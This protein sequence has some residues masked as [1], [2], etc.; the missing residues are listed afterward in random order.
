MLALAIAKN[1]D[2][3]GCVLEWEESLVDE[4][5]T[6][7]AY[8]PAQNILQAAR[9]SWNEVQPGLRKAVDDNIIGRYVFSEQVFRCAGFAATFHSCS[10]RSASRQACIIAQSQVNDSCCSSHAP[11]RHRL[12]SGSS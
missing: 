3:A 6:T 12:C 8:E 10:R 9:A 1:L 7:S 5:Q 4:L 11:V 2:A